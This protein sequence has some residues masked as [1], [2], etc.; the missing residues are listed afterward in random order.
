[1]KH[2]KLNVNFRTFE[3]AKEYVDLNKFSVDK[4]EI[5]VYYDPTKNWVVR[6]REYDPHTA[7]LQ[8]S[9]PV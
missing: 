9:E 4:N 7:E 2:A 3:E 5:V 8:Q 6:K 1:M